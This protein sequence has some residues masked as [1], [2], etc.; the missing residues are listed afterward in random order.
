[1]QDNEASKYQ[2]LPE[3]TT[4]LSYLTDWSEFKTPFIIAC[5]ITDNIA[6]QDELRPVLREMVDLYYQAKKLNALLYSDAFW[7]WYKV[8]EKLQKIQA[9]H[10]EAA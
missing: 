4:Y 1:M 8:N 3:F 2:L 9:K 10:L 5:E 6:E 7:A